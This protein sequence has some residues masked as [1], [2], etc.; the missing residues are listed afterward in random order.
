MKLSIL[1]A[2][3]GHR[4]Q[5]FLSLIHS[6]MPMVKPYKGQIEVLA[7]WNNGEL[8]IGKIRKALIQEAKGDYVCF[9]DDDDCVPEYYCE[10]IM[11]A[12]RDSCPDYVGF[13][14]QL[15][16]EGIEAKPVYHSIIYKHWHEDERGYYRGVTHLNPIKRS[17]A[18]DGDFGTS[19]EAGED[20]KWAQ[21][22]TPLVQRE[23][24]IDRVMYQ[25]YHDRSDTNFGGD[26][27]NDGHYK[28]PDFRHK[29]FRFH[30]DSKETS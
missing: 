21:S 11:E 25:Y 24:Y 18:L 29:Y 8:P 16:N 2:T 20:A 7:Y 27:H 3:I 30:K 5:R 22:V 4:E 23:A 1:I 9:I 13:K 19:H 15:F 10:L 12:L 26:K 28:R 14:V 17:I 6:L